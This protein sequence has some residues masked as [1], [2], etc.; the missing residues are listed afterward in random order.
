MNEK[1]NLRGG[2]WAKNLDDIDREV[3]RLAA[4]CNVKVLDAGVI[5]HILE[6]DESVCG[7]RNAPAFAKLRDAMKM[8][9]HI[10]TKA[11]EAMGEHAT[12]RIIEQIVEDLR[13]RI[14]DRLGGTQP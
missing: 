14:G 7:T 9:Y 6:G 2:W 13:Q 12:A 5:A 1:G 4:I 10:R 8:H 11:V 3:A